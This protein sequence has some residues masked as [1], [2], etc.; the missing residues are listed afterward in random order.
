MFEKPEKASV[1]PRSPVSARA[2][3]GARSREKRTT[4]SVARCCASAALSRRRR[5]IVAAKAS[6]GDTQAIM[7]VCIARLQ[8]DRLLVVSEV[9]DPLGPLRRLCRRPKRHRTAR[10]QRGRRR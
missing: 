5:A 4:S 9:G 6:Q 8:L 7:G 3:I 10:R 1:G 2:A